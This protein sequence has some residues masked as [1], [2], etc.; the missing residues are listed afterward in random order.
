VPGPGADRLT[1]EQPRASILAIDT[2]TVPV[3]ALL[4]IVKRRDGS[5]SAQGTG[6]RSKKIAMDRRRPTAIFTDVLK[7]SQGL[8]TTAV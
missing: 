8:T 7:T 5:T 3:V 6:R 2:V 4:K 1:S